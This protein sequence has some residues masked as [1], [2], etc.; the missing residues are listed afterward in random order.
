MKALVAMAPN[1]VIGLDGR[2][3]WPHL[4]EDMKF[5]VQQTRNTTLIVGR[6]TLEGLP[7]MLNRKCIALTNSSPWDL[8]N[9]NYYKFDALYL[10]KYN[11]ECWSNV[12]NVFGPCVVC[13]GAQIYDL[14]LPLCSELFVTHIKKDYDGDA[15][16]PVSQI[17]NNFN[18]SEQLQETPDFKIVR[19]FK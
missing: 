18:K 14:M 10:R 16:F 1:G 5:F 12:E 19:Y 4:K 17:T 6:K 15:F 7:K 13:G 2:L 8:F 9:Q 11:E 3:P